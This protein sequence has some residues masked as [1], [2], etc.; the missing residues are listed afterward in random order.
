MPR[1]KT[2]I[3]VIKEYIDPRDMPPD[4]PK[5]FTR[6]SQL[7]LELLENKVKIKQELVN[8]AHIHSSPGGE[9]HLPQPAPVL[10]VE[11]NPDVKG[12]GGDNQEW[13]DRYSEWG[14]EDS[15]G[16]DWDDRYSDRGVDRYSD[17][18]VDRYSDRGDDRYSDRGVDRYSDRGDDRY[19]D[20]GD[21]RYSDRGDDSYSDRESDRD[22]DVSRDPRKARLPDPSVFKDDPVKVYSPAASK[23]YNGDGYANRE[24]FKRIVGNKP[25]EYIEIIDDG[26]FQEGDIIDEVVDPY[27]NDGERP[28]WAQGSP[29]HS[30]EHETSRS[31][32]YSYDYP[33]DRDSYADEDPVLSRKERKRARRAE[34]DHHSA[35]T[36]DISQRSVGGMSVRLNELLGDSGREDDRG[37]HYRGDKY[38]RGYDD[39]FIHRSTHRSATYRD[40]FPKQETGAPSLAQLEAAG[41]YQGQRVIPVLDQMN[42]AD[43]EDQKR[44]LIF[45]FNLLR[46]SFPGS[47]IPEFSVH[48]D[49]DTM[50]KSYDD[51]VRRL[52]LDSSVEN[53]KTYLLGGFIMVEYGLGYWGGLDMD[54]FVK[55]QVI[56]MNQ[57][58]RLLIEMGEKSYVPEGSRWSVE[59]RL[60]CLIL[61]NAVVFIVGKMIVKHTGGDL[62]SML[63][64]LGGVSTTSAQT[65]P[66]RKMRGPNINLG[67]SAM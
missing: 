11:R 53:Y 22:R 36:D 30:L 21:D 56:Q 12:R 57:Y 18:G 19:S 3:K 24:A 29:I 17:R 40:A 63:S 6:M 23:N 46:K 39:K 67:D 49:L 13:D 26:E 28:E 35:S 37:R 47:S 7:Y 9:R 66:K 65:A 25:K 4:R 64:G 48:S 55:K 62:M 58:E 31:T 54:G 45:K 52:S 1:R 5:A 10:N 43:S 42:T 32:T 61:F 59:V 60:A 8:K 50:Q 33:N 38:S 15:E 34:R 27:N 51:S 44:E 41:Q 20:R 16:R 2:I 14:G